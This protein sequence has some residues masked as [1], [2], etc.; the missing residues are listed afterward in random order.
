M[1]QFVLLLALPA[2][3]LGQPSQLGHAIQALYNRIDSGDDNRV[4]VAEFEGYFL[5]FDIDDDQRLSHIEFV[6]ALY[7]ASSGFSGYGL[8]LFSL[9][10]QNNDT[11]LTRSDIEDSF[12]VADRNND[13]HLTEPELY[14]FIHSGTVVIG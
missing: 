8:Q 10:D 9:F 12:N 4:V 2:V 13:T 11:N 6:A 14:Q 3:L 5:A 7:T 1:F